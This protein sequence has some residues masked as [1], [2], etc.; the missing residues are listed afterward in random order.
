MSLTKAT[1]AMVE[2]GFANPLDYGAVGDGTANDTAALTAAIAVGLD[3][4]VPKGFT[5]ATLGNVT[6]FSNGQRVFG[7]GTIKKIGAGLN[8][9]VL[10]PDLIENVTFENITF[11]GNKALYTAGQP[12]PAILGY[13][14]RSITVKNCTFQNIVDC[15]VKLRDGAGLLVDGCTFK[16]IDT[17]GIEVRLYTNDPRTGS[18]YPV[19]P[20]NRDYRIVNSYFNKIDDGTGGAGEG[21]GVNIASNNGLYY[22]ENIVVS[23]NT[24]EDVLRS[25]FTEN[26]VAGGE[27]RNMSI[28]GNTIVGNVLGAATVETKDGIGLVNAI[29]VAISGNTIRNVGNFVPVGGVCAAVQVS[30][31]ACRNIVI[32][33]NAFSDDTGDP[34]RTDY[35]VYLNEGASVIVRNNTIEGM[36]QA[37]IGWVGTPSPLIADGNVGAEG[38]YSWGSTTPYV[39]QRI[40]VPAASATLAMYPCGQT[41][42]DEIPVPC[43]G[44]VVGLSV[45][46]STPITAGAI[47]FKAYSNGIHRTAL[48]ITQADF[49]GGVAFA[50][51][52]SVTDADAVTLTPGQRLRVY[53]TTDGSFTPTTLDALAVVTFDTSVKFNS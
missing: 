53:I 33:G 10:L 35:G 30:G 3:V 14:T 39:F 32:T 18:P 45:L 20:A 27:A 9:V 28:L 4:Y 37:A 36:S 42:W 13:V 23:N 47:T 31:N 38:E 34:D 22:T 2:Q 41:D 7:G 25:I 6:G 51:A 43:R 17:N 16:N 12:V 21:C 52:I 19:R 40:N 24:F 44:A 29:G 1:F 5:F 8:P 50:K 11:D 46:L 49:A 48:D 15:G 26:N